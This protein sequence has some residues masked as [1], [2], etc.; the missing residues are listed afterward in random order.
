MNKLERLEH[1]GLVQEDLLESQEGRKPS[2]FETIANIRVSDAIKAVSAI[3]EEQPVEN[4]T[5]EDTEADRGS[6]G[7][8]GS[9]G[10]SAGGASPAA[11]G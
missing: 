8:E 9:A 6:E 2:S 10:R 5:A 11:Q 7:G 3:A 4:V 1:L